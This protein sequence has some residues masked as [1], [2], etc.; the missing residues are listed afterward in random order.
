MSVEHLKEYARRCAT[1]PEL[2]ARAKAIGFAD[3][4]AHIEHGKSLGLEFSMEDAITYRNQ[5]VGA[6]MEM[7]EVGSEELDQIAGGV[8]SVTSIAV[9]IAVG[10]AAGLAGAAAVGG[11]GIAVGAG[12]A[13]S[14]W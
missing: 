8:V 9:G 5:V 2:R 7:A 10:A 13:G 1:E 12:I 11:V 14:G 6:D 3:P 4:D